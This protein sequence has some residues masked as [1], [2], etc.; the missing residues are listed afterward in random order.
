MDQP[1]GIATDGT[2]IWIVD[3]GAGQVL[4]YAGAA[5]LTTG[6][7]SVAESFS[8]DSQNTNASGI[9]TDGST[10]WVSD[11]LA[12]AVFA[13]DIAS[14]FLGRWSLDPGNVDASGVTNDLAGGTDLLVQLRAGAVRAGLVVD[15]KRIPE[16]TGLSLYGDGLRLGA[17]VCAAA[18]VVSFN[19]KPRHFIHH[20]INGAKVIT[21][22]FIQ[23]FVQ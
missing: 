13:Y 8:L 3:A 1:E 7:A 2:D 4:R 14:N 23:R 19:Q 20:R 12:D 11:D 16:L 10:L 17:A 18:A 5:L 15:L 22:F 21:Q 9:A 6:L